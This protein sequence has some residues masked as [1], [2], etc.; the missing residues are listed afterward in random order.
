MQNLNLRQFDGEVAHSSR[1]RYIPRYAVSAPEQPIDP[2]FMDD[3]DYLS[4]ENFET[5]S[6]N[7]EENEE[8]IPPTC[9]VRPNKNLI[10]ELIEVD[11]LEQLLNLRGLQIR[12]GRPNAEETTAASLRL[13]KIG[14][15]I[16][17]QLVEW[18]K[19]LPFYNELP[20]EVHTHLLTQR[21]SELVSLLLYFSLVHYYPKS[22][23]SVFYFG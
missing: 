13:S 9:F 22:S 5:E 7:E 4:D 15:E 20:V 18:T 11:R 23:D 3:E 1:I 10:Q 6:R 8:A 14:D 21:W 19:V 2:E 17:E 16:V 12:G